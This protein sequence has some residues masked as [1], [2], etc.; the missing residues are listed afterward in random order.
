MAL[1]SSK[2]LWMTHIHYS[3][4]GDYVIFIIYTDDDGLCIS[5]IIIITRMLRKL[6]LIGKS[7]C[8]KERNT[9]EISAVVKKDDMRL[10]L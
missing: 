8:K 7:S 9:Y 4:C 10:A 6:L 2:Q 1:S 3:L 5:I